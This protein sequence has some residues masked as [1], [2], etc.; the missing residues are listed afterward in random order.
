LSDDLQSE[1][2]NALLMLLG[3]GVLYAKWK[4]WM[5]WMNLHVVPTMM[6][7]LKLVLY[8]SLALLALYILWEGFVWL[9][10]YLQ[11][12]RIIPRREYYNLHADL[13]RTINELQCCKQNYNR[14]L[15]QIQSLESENAKIKSELAKAKEKPEDVTKSVIHDLLGRRPS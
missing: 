12:H 5:N 2:I 7:G 13:T 9:C 11:N 3:V 10:A 8:A 6:A 14:A 4:D 15:G 1:K